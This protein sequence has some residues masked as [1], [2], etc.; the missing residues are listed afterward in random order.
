MF[1]NVCVCTIHLKKGNAYAYE[2]ITKRMQELLIHICRYKYNYK[3]THVPILT[4]Q[5]KRYEAS[6]I[7]CEHFC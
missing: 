6:E 1:V 7:V 2:R 4:L 5:R 3:C